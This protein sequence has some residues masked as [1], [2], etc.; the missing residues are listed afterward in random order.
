MVTGPLATVSDA[1]FYLRKSRLV[2]DALA[3][4][5]KTEYDDALSIL[6]NARQEIG[7]D[8]R[9]SLKYAPYEHTC[10]NSI[11]ADDC[12]ACRWGQNIVELEHD[13]I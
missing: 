2:G 1:A 6:N 8:M 12:P 3:A 11:L 5:Y 4:R 7:R 10:D 13:K 9:L